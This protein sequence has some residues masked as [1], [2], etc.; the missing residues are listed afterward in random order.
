MTPALSRRH[1][2]S[3]LFIANGTMWTASV[4]W[5]ITCD[6]RDLLHIEFE[7]DFPDGAF[8]LYDNEPACATSVPFL[9]WRN[10]ERYKPVKREF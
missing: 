6:I 1:R 10:A 2:F 4:L 3:R 9:D 5:R 8:A 7:E